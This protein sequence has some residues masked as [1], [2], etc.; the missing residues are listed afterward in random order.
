MVVETS[1]ALWALLRGATGGTGP[2]WVLG[3]VVEAPARSRGTA[4]TGR[5]TAGA[6][7]LAGVGVL[8]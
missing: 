4:L 1:V 2:H 3:Y 5:I 7:L 6:A 8:G